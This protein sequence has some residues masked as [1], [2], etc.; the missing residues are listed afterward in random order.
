MLAALLLAGLT[1]LC[2]SAA[3]VADRVLVMSLCGAKCCCCW[4][5]TGKLRWHS[6][7]LKHWR[8]DGK[9]IQQHQRDER[10]VPAPN[11]TTNSKET[12]HKREPAA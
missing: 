4:S 5:K 9:C 7:R 6:G 10:R 12:T 8:S 1:L 3:A 11:N 2:M